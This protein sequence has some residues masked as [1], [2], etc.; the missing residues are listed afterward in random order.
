MSSET[1]YIE[2]A[3]GRTFI[4]TSGCKTRRRFG[5]HEEDVWI[6][7]VVDILCA[8]DGKKLTLTPSEVKYRFKEIIVDNDNNGEN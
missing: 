4:Q 7:S 6:E 3:T 2:K 5:E 1:V 8:Q